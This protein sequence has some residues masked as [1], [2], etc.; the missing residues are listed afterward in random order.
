MKGTNDALENARVGE[1][2]RTK[3]PMSLAESD[4]KESRWLLSISGTVVEDSKR[5]TTVFRRV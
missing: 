1:I 4:A 2:P 3:M 5:R